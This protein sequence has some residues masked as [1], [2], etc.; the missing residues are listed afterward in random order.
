[1]KI[2]EIFNIYPGDD[3]ELN[4]SNYLDFFYHAD[5]ET[6]QVSVNEEP[7]C[8]DNISRENYAYVAAM[9]EKL[10][11]DYSLQYPQWIFKGDYFLRDPWFPDY[12]KGRARIY[13]MLYAPIEFLRRNLYVSENVLTRV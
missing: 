10:C 2:K 11:T 6:R 3:I 5:Q 8:N 9:V 1:M 4:I 7:S 12:V 13:L